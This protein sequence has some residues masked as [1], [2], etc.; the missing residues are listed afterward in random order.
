MA[1]GFLK[2]IR[3][4][5]RSSFKTDKS[6]TPDHHENVPRIP[7]THSN[8]ASSVGLGNGSQTPPNAFESTS[9]AQHESNGASITRPQIVTSGNHRH[10]VSGMS[11]LGS[12][13]Q[14]MSIPTSQYAPR[15]LSIQDNTWVGQKPL[16]S[17][18][19]NVNNFAG[20]PKGTLGLRDH[21]RSSTTSSRRYP[22]GVQA[23]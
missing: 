23:G 2:D 15:I 19:L 18:C 3:R 1:P 5:S 9:N 8:S 17:Y 11:G 16:P 21:R 4:R 12:P 6:G 20:V 10:S 7:Q 14:T 22:D 13:T